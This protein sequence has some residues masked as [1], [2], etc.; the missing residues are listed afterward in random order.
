MKFK[1]TQGNWKINKN[2]SLVFAGKTHIRSYPVGMTVE[3]KN[4]LK[5]I[6]SAPEL[7]EAL[8]AITNNLE[9]WVETGEVLDAKESKALYDNAKKAINKAII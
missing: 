5:L 2:E 6:A 4:D 3:Q 8:Q 7:L 9:N 1:G